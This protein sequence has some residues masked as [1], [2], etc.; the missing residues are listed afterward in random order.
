MESSHFSSAVFCIRA[1]A[2]SHLAVWE[3]SARHT[4]LLLGIFPFGVRFEKFSLRHCSFDYTPAKTYSFIQFYLNN[5]KKSGRFPSVFCLSNF[6]RDRGSAYTAWPHRVEV[7]DIIGVY[8]V[9]TSPKRL[10]TQIGKTLYSALMKY[11]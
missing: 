1:K 8:K 10:M 5:V 6:Q 7:A 11:N 9:K 3:S 4:V 2:V